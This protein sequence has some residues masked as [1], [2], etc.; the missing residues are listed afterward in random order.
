MSTSQGPI[1]EV[2]FNTQHQP[3]PPPLPERS[4]SLSSSL[5]NGL[6]SFPNYNTPQSRYSPTQQIS[7]CITMVLLFV[8]MYTL[9][10]GWYVAMNDV[11]CIAG[12]FVMD[13]KY[14]LK[15]SELMTITC[16][17]Y[18]HFIAVVWSFIVALLSLFG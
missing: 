12:S 6:P 4:L 1:F 16:S 5:D 9:C 14:S 17:H 10:A 2:P 7:K 13:R 18:L 15:W 8:C 3:P 11:T